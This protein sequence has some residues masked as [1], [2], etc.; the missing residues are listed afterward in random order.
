M[1]KAVTST[2]SIFLTLIVVTV[3]VNAQETQTPSMKIQVDVGM[4]HNA[5]IAFAINC[6]APYTGPP[7]ESEDDFS[8]ES[9][10]IPVAVLSDVEQSASFDINSLILVP[11]YSATLSQSPSDEFGTQAG[12]YSVELAETD[13]NGDG[14]NDVIFYFQKIALF[15]SSKMCSGASELLF[16][17]EIN[18]ANGPVILSGSDTIAP[19]F[20]EEDE[21]AAEEPVAPAGVGLNVSKAYAM[22]QGSQAYQF[23]A[24]GTGISDIHVQ[25]FGLDGNRVFDSGFVASNTLNW[26]GLSD[27]GIAVANGVYLYVITVK[28]FSGEIERSSVNKLII[29]R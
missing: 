23:V 21:P 11:A 16:N 14:L 4:D 20:T 26:N 2:L 7:Q 28:G 5:D 13:L 6:D 19:Q 24:Q 25:I 17:L 22:A 12:H 9:D 1:F 18:T 8:L 27:N 15:D 3:V 10:I 29:L